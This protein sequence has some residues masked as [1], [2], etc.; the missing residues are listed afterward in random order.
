MIHIT[1]MTPESCELEARRKDHGTFR[2]QLVE[3]HGPVFDGMAGLMLLIVICLLWVQ[4]FG[5]P[6]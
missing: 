1:P 4:V 6:L 3:A 5:S 2:E